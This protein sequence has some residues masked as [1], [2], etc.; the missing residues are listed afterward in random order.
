MG[1]L[2]AEELIEYL[3]LLDPETQIKTTDGKNYIGIGLT[4]VANEKFAYLEEE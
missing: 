4:G 1:S 3:R 2:K